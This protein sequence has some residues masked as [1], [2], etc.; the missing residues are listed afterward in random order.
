[1]K[2]L[3]ILLVVAGHIIQDSVVGGGQSH[4]TYLWIYKFH[5]DVFFFCSGCLF[6]GLDMEKGILSGITIFQKKMTRLLIPYIT[7]TCIIFCIDHK[8]F[9][10]ENILDYFVFRPR[11][12]L[13]F[14]QNMMLYCLFVLAIFA[15]LRYIPKKFRQLF[16][17]IL[18]LSFMI[19]LAFFGRRHFF[20]YLMGI[21]FV[22]NFIVPKLITNKWV[23]IVTSIMFL[24][25]IILSEIPTRLVG[26]SAIIVFYNIGRTYYL[27]ELMKNA[28]MLFGKYSM[29]IFLVHFFITMN[30]QIRCATDPFV[31]FALSITS[32]IVISYF[33]IAL[34]KLS[35]VGI[36]PTIL[37]GEKI[38]LFSNKLTKTL[39]GNYTKHKS[40]EGRK[41]SF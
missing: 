24:V 16:E 18:L 31:L 3:A 36:L 9:I 22:R 1:M 25:S 30:I 26:F 40:H 20:F 32:S 21:L 28:I 10:L 37:W 7:W 41:T 12:G 4:P 6:S 33:C 5:M 23:L 34:Y 19:V 38:A 15:T 8:P 17:N 13:W 11:Y 39:F 2:G 14:L 35:L 27:P 29:P